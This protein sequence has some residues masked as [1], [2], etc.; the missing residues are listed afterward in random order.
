MTRERS[1]SSATNRPVTVAEGRL[2]SIT[3]PAYNEANT[4]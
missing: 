3:C 1:N 2:I 4:G